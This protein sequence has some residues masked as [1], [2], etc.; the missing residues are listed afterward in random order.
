MNGCPIGASGITWTDVYLCIGALIALSLAF[1]L[2]RAVL[3][4]KT[5]KTKP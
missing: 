4:P 1:S 2:W 5:E 3:F